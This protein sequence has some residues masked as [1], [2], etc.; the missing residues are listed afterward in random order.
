MRETWKRNRHNEGV[1]SQMLFVFCVGAGTVCTTHVATAW[2]TFA[3]LLH[4]NDDD[5]HI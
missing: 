3:W 5:K 1:M 2:L 4:A